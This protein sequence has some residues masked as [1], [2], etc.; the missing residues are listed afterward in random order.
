M[1]DYKVY[2]ISNK[3][4][5]THVKS[6][7]Q[8]ANYLDCDERVKLWCLCC[9]LG[10]FGGVVAFPVSLIGSLIACLSRP[11]NDRSEDWCDASQALLM[12]PC[13][14]FSNV[15]SDNSYQFSSTAISWR[16]FDEV[17]GVEPKSIGCI[18]DHAGVLE[19]QDTRSMSLEEQR[20]VAGGWTNGVTHFYYIVTNK[21]KP[22]VNGEMLEI[23]RC[24]DHKNKAQHFADIQNK[25]LAD[26]QNKKLVES[27][28]LLPQR[29]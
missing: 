20:S 25:K 2:A 16:H 27:Q 19:P 17:S 5:Y 21:E 9:G 13:V 12:M 4:F 11:C 18:K 24:F 29:K 1:P 3:N 8:A 26:I 28:P 6:A 7:T 22:A 10:L 23:D 15:S 14:L